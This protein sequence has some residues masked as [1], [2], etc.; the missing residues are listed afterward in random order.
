MDYICE[1]HRAIEV[2]VSSIEKAIEKIVDIEQIYSNKTG[3]MELRVDGLLDRIDK[4]EDKMEDFISTAKD[5]NTVA[6]NMG[7]LVEQLREHGEK[8]SNIENKPGVLAI[9]LWVIV[10]NSIVS[11]CIGWAVSLMYRGF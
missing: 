5:L 11:A 7:G 4:V 6:T 3:I 8:I 10:G 9:K 1:H 2:R